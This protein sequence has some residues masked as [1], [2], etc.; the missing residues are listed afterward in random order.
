MRFL[1]KMKGSSVELSKS[2]SSVATAA[3]ETK[4]WWARGCAFHALMLSCVSVS[5]THKGCVACMVS[6]RALG[7]FLGSFARHHNGEERAMLLI[8]IVQQLL[9]AQL[10]LTN[11]NQQRT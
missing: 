2:K 3:S 4:A 5:V 10:G 1:A 9:S 7:G 6:S 8:A 11:M